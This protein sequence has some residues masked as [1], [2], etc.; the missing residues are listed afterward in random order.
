MTA[1]HLRNHRL[2]GR[3]PRSC[4]VIARIVTSVFLLATSVASIADTPLEPDEYVVFH[5]HD[6]LGNTIVTT[7]ANGEVLWFEQTEPYGKTL[8]KRNVR[9]SGLSVDPFYEEEG[10]SRPGYTGHV[11]DGATGLTYMQARHYSPELGRF[12]SNDPIGV[13]FS[14]LQSFNRYAYAN[15][16]P[17]RYV[18]PDGRTPDMLYVG[19][20]RAYN[21]IIGN[22]ISADPYTREGSQQI[23]DYNS[24]TAF[25]QLDALGVLGGIGIGAKAAKVAV[26]AKPKVSPSTLH[27][28][29]T[30]IDGGRK[31]ENTLAGS[32]KIKDADG[33][34]FKRTDYPPS[35]PH[36]DLSP[37]THP[38]YR[39]ALPDGTN[40]SGVSRAARKVNQQDVIDASRENSQRTGE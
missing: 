29:G 24:E 19:D 36:S 34:I 25:K 37:H 4:L 10:R 11:R 30:K 13:N 9:G 33:N 17:Y 15:N 20:P 3:W 40:R 1:R 23:A 39:N 18:D 2:S 6:A 12:L 31:I 21:E 22:F 16:N 7:G 8:G 38:N 14:N 28:R 35:K 27:E 26:K 5:H 32:N